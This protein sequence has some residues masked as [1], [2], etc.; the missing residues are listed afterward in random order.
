MLDWGRK[1]IME[2]K[3]I[4]I[5]VLTETGSETAT[6][7]AAELN[8]S[9]LFL[10]VKFQTKVKAEYF[11]P[12]EFTSILEENWTKF[13]AHIFI[14]ATGIV[15]RKIAGLLKDKT[16]DPAVVVCDEKGQFAISLLSGHIGGANRLAREI[17]VIL[18]GQAVITTATDVQ[19]IMAFDELAAIQ[20]WQIK[21][22][23]NIKLLNSLLLAAEPI[24][25][26]LPEKIFQ[27]YFHERKNISLLNNINDLKNKPY[28]GA[29]VHG[30]ENF[31]S[32]IDFPVLYL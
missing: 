14:M 29:V 2:E 5:Y 11:G 13:D 25:V 15:V 30:E 22:P 26:I 20:G 7:L 23:E 6:K 17:A 31:P 18:K 9:G 28:K 27:E 3:K 1:I 21:N 16:V 32:A 8:A 12:G 24:A 10:P 19:G 4:A